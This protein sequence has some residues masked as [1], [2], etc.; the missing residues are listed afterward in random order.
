MSYMKSCKTNVTQKAESSQVKVRIAFERARHVNSA[1]SVDAEEV[2]LP[3][4]EGRD[5]SSAAPSR[6]RSQRRDHVLWRF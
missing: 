6:E 1:T 5:A 4:S 3:E 2:P